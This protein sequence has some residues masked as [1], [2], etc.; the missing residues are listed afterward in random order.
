MLQETPFLSRHLP[1][2]AGTKLANFGGRRIARRR[3][4]RCVAIHQ[5]RERVSRPF[6]RAR[7]CRYTAETIRVISR[8][9][10]SRVG[11]D[12]RRGEET[13]GVRAPV[14]VAGESVIYTRSAPNDA[15]RLRARPG[16]RRPIR[17]E[18]VRLHTQRNFLRCLMTHNL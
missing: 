12:E 10:Y 7:G 14:D 5:L 11:K 17:D 16:A 9:T 1:P 8:V 15:K 18:R 6:F 4:L 2:P 13:R 3:A